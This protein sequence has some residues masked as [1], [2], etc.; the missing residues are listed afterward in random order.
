MTG[1]GSDTTYKN[2]DLEWFII[3]LPTVYPS[4]KWDK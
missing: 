4:Y 3:V 1:N 2:G